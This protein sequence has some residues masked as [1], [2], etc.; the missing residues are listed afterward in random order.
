MANM[1]IE[2]GA[3]AGLFRV[4]DKTLLYIKSRAKRDYTVYDPDED[5]EYARV[6]EYDVT[7]LEPQ[8][9]TFGWRG[10]S[11]V[12]TPTAMTG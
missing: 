6:I 8:V 3:K 1:A 9:S 4:D 2:A 5:A 11:K 7:N 10:T 12:T